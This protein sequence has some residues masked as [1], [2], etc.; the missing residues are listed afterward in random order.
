MGSPSSEVCAAGGSSS[1]AAQLQ[2]QR[3]HDCTGHSN[4]FSTMASV[5]ASRDAMMRSALSSHGALPSCYPPPAR[6]IPLGI[7]SLRVPKPTAG[8][9]QVAPHGAPHG[10]PFSLAAMS[11]QIASMRQLQRNGSD[12]IIYLEGSGKGRE[13]EPLIS[14]HR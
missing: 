5:G 8:P 7:T 4:G 10:D 9:H 2:P 6:A 1:H 3:G 12:A 14:G 11:G 13:A